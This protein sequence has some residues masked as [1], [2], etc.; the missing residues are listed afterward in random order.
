[1]PIALAPLG[2]ELEIKR[3]GAEDK[4]KRHL[5]EMGIT[6]GGKITVLSAQG[7]N[8]IVVVKEGRLCLD[9]EIARKILVA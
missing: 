5:Q 8:V 7:G 2:A 4:T 9:K 6:V 1:M 3:V